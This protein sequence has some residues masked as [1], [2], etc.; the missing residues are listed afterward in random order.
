MTSPAASPSIPPPDALLGDLLV[1]LRL[2]TVRRLWRELATAAARD[3]WSHARFLAALCEHELQERDTRRIQRRREEANLPLGKTFQ[4]FDFTLA[5]GLSAP[6][7][8]ELATGGDWVRQGHNILMFGPHGVGKTHLAA[9]VADE[10]ITQ[11]CRARYERVTDLLQCLQGARR[12]L[13]LPEA[14]AKL[15]RYDVLVLDDIGYARKDQHETDVLFELIAQAYERRSL[16]ITSN[17]PFGS[18]EALFQDKA[19][20]V[21][22]IDRLVHHA[23]IIEMTGESHRRR[24]ATINAKR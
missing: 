2:P 8:R 19:M 21:A 17:Q 13:R 1:S 15:D 7:L 24:Q 11:G 16:I 23:V 6:R 9:A 14:L 18:W 4:T 10:L 22:A 5:P 20:T 12:D 3:G